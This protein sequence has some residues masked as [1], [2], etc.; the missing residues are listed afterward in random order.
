VRALVDADR[1]ALDAVG[2]YDHGADPYFWTRDY[3]R[4]G[5]VHLVVPPGEVGDWPIRVMQVDDQLGVSFLIVDLWTREEGASDL[6]LEINFSLDP[7]NS[8]VRSE[9]VN[10]HVM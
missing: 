8:S 3:G 5:D 9:F 6:S 7:G 2:A 1:A 4:L 10:L